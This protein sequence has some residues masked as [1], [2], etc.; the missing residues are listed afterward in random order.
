[1]IYSI[2]FVYQFIGVAEDEVS[3]ETTKLAMPL[4]LVEISE[5]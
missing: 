5:T 4:V 2:D 1:M 3:T